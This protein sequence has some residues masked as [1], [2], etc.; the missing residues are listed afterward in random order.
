MA[1]ALDGGTVPAVPAPPPGLTEIGEH[2]PYLLA[3]AILPRLSRWQLSRLVARAIDCLDAIDGDPEAQQSDGDDEDGNASEDDFMIH[4]SEHGPRLSNSRPG[5]LPSQ[6][7]PGRRFNRGRRQGGR[8]RRRRGRRP[9]RRHARRAWRMSGLLMGAAVLR[10]PQRNK[11]RKRKS[12]GCLSMGRISLR[13][14]EREGEPIPPNVFELDEVRRGEPRPA[15][16][17]EALFL[18]LAIFTRLPA[19]DKKII[20]NAARY[21]ADEGLEIARSLYRLLT[22]EA[23]SEPP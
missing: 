14:I 18:S 11:G 13:M 3:M 22:G 23:P 12:G 9:Q 8:R 5:L 19:E 20:R 7:R 15:E 10:F 21:K 16:A 2:V 6:R 1:R 4:S 17:T